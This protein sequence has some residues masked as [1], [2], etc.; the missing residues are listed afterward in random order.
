MVCP[1]LLTSCLGTHGCKSNSAA[2][3][4]FNFWYTKH[5]KRCCYFFHQFISGWQL[6]PLLQLLEGL[7]F[8][9]LKVVNKTTVKLKM[10]SA[11]TRTIINSNI[12]IAAKCLLASCPYHLLVI[13]GAA[14]T[15]GKAV[16]NVYNESARLDQRVPNNVL[17]FVRQLYIYRI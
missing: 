9:S 2:N 1:V 4:S 5:P 12:K 15:M 11:T 6:W 13:G 14:T 10:C 17:N 8:L 3:F 16:R 7:C